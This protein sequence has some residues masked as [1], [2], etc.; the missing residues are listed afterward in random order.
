MKKAALEV[1]SFQGQTSQDALHEVLR[2]GARR[3]LQSALE[4]EIELIIEKT[5]DLCDEQG[6]R[7]VRRNGWLPERD[8]LTSVGPLPVKVPRVRDTRPAE[9]RLPAEELRGSLLP[10]YV[11]KAKTLEELLPALYLS[12]LSTGHFQEAL[13]ALLGPSAKGLSSSTITRCMETWQ[14][15]HKEWCQAPLPADE[16][17]MIWA[18]AI[19]CNVRLNKDRPCILVIIGATRDGHKH[20]L[21]IDDGMRESE[22]SWMTLLEKMKQR[23][24]TK[25]PRLAIADGALG[26][27]AALRKVFPSCEEQ[28]CWVHKIANI[29]NALPKSLH[30]TA[31]EDLRAIWNAATRQEALKAIAVFIR[32][33]EDKY[34]KAVKCLTKD[35]ESLLTFF[36]FPAEHWRHIRT[37]NVIES[38][39]ATVRLRTY[40][41][42]GGGSSAATVAMVFKLAKQAEKSWRRL[43]GA[44]KLEDVLNFVSFRDGVAATKVA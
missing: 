9:E 1:P 14:K 3:L 37:T 31:K 11:R 34:P 40:R 20:L 32:K 29:L 21:A 24:L 39:F 6:R 33:F 16:Y 27:W 44:S 12:G 36:S 25:P 35:Q 15:E 8:L 4:A 19:Y 2:E 10:R 23:G 26:F 43:N 30:D 42:K 22:I 28:R 18:D 7:F 5:K 13:T 41:T 17:V 38:A